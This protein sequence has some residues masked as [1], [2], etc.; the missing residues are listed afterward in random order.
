MSWELTQGVLV[1]VSGA[2][3][4]R[5]RTDAGRLVNVV[6]V[7]IADRKNPEADA[8]LRSWIG[9]RVSV[10]GNYHREGDV[11]MAEVNDATTGKDLA[12]E[13]LR[14]GAATFEPAAPYTLSDYSEC[15]N[16]IAERE[17]KAERLGIWR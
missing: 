5:V 15:L 1:E 17:A 6:V 4:V 3:T 14:M 9:R 2:Q 12:R 16:R 10:V 8:I 13:L 7:N 11:I